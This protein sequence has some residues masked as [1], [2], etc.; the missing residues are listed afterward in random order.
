MLQ[1][2]MKVRIL[3]T[4]PDEPVWHGKV[5]KL[6]EINEQNTDGDFFGVNF[7][8]E[9]TYD[10]AHHVVYSWREELEMV[11]SSETSVTFP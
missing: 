4:F 8:D 7:P 11:A 1:I 3:P 2:G 9:A 5:G 6:V 10:T